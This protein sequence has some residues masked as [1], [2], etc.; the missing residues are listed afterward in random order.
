MATTFFVGI[1]VDPGSLDQSTTNL[2]VGTAT[3]ATCVLELRMNSSTVALTRHQVMM[4][5][6]MFKRWVEQGGVNQAGAN[7][8]LPTGSG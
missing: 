3:T 2:T 7:L 4:G 8:P 6:E 5:L 1:N